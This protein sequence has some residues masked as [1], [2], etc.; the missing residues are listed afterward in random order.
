[1]IIY[2]H[3]ES[4]VRSVVMVKLGVL[5]L[6]SMKKV[7][8]NGYLVCFFGGNWVGLRWGIVLVVV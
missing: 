2:K 6:C 1:M 8:Q 4:V 5:L 3:I 7:T